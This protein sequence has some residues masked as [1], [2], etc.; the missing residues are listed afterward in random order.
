[1]KQLICE[2]C[3]SADL[4][5]QDGVFVCQVCGCKYSVEEVR[6]M[7]IEGTVSIDGVV[8]TRNDDFEVRA[9]ELVAY[10]GAETD[11][12]IPDSIKIIGKMCFKDMQGIESVTIPEGVYKIQ[13]FAFCGCSGLKK[14]T[15]PQ[16]LDE[17]EVAAFKGC[18]SL[19]SVQLP[20]GI[21]VI[22]SECFQNC[23]SIESIHIPNSIQTLGNDTFC[24]CVSL[25]SVQ[26][27]GGIKSIGDCCFSGCISLKSIILPGSIQ[28]FGK[29]CFSECASLESVNVSDGIQL[30]GMECFRDCVS[31]KLINF[32]NS[33]REIGS[34]C[35]GCRIEGYYQYSP[36]CTSLKSVQLPDGVQILGEGCF[37]GCT[38]LES[39]RISEGIQKIGKQAFTTTPALKTVELPAWY[40]KSL[41][42]RDLGMMAS[43]FNDEIGNIESPWFRDKF[44]ELRS[45]ELKPKNSGCY[46]ATA[47]YGSYDC[48]QVWT[49]RRYR[50]DTLAE[51][52]YGRVFIRIYYTVSPTLVKRFGHT[53]WF[54]KLWKV[55]LDRMVYNLNSEGVED[56]P[57]QDRAW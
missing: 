57:Y 50:D 46:I 32:P 14:I 29:G 40:I 22:G 47:V 2:M 42:V 51:T 48:P 3:G 36:G 17:I 20:D 52:W 27:P 11:V 30:L 25:K 37:R 9:G 15:F 1:M 4:I 8:K 53:E 24:Q 45:K 5:K 16:S 12:V 10:H 38:S 19:K 6:K 43:Q 34:Y 55:K 54:K 44:E 28:T 56:T 49:L 18:T 33:L 7:M 21:Q 26:L 41:T 35:F 31:L 23:K 13:Y 39:I